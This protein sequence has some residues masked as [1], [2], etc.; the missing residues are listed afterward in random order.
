MDYDSAAE[1]PK[2]A[3]F[4]EMTCEL[5]RIDLA[6]MKSDVRLAFCINLYNLMIQHAFAKLGPPFSTFKRG[7][8]FSNVSY[9]VGGLVYSLNS[10]EGGVLRGNRRQPY[11]WF[12][13]FGSRD[14]RLATSLPRLDPRIH[15]ALNC[16]AK[17]CPPVKKFTA[18]A[19]DQ[20]LTFV[21]Q[22]FCEQEENIRVP[23]RSHH[24]ERRKP[25]PRRPGK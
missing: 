12:R 14:P 15:F 16:G 7:H 11:T 18:E 20:E 22:A 25:S 5:Q 1:D 8:F 13:P 23:V 4:D 19:V 24:G 3:G 2:F 17:S 6:A 10:L 21:A 9:N